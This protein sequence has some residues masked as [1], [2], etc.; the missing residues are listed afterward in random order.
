MDATGLKGR[1]DIHMDATAYMAS[2]GSEGGGHMDVMSFLFTALQQQLGLKLESRKDKPEI[3]V[4]DS[5][6]KTPA[7]N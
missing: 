2:P 3:L 7:E 4:V 1:Y 6:E 5:V